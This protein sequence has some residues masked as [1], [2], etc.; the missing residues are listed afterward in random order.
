MHRDAIAGLLQLGFGLYQLLVSMDARFSVQ[1]DGL[2]SPY[3]LV[4]PYLGMA[5]VNTV[6]NILDPPYS[7]ITVLDISHA[8]DGCL[9]STGRIR[10][11]LHQSISRRSLLRYD[12]NLCNRNRLVRRHLIGRQIYESR[13][14]LFGKINRSTSNRVRNRRHRIC[15]STILETGPGLN[16]WSG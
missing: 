2:A 7:V 10:R 12:M 6:I 11:L 14:R 15:S 3:L 9:T 5:A 13:P 1:K 4:L 16:S 8:R